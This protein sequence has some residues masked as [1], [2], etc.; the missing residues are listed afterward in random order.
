M[1]AEALIPLS[2]A[3]MHHTTIIMAGDD[4]QLGPVLQSPRF[5]HNLFIQQ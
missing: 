2:L 4:K 5:I 3:K 1:E